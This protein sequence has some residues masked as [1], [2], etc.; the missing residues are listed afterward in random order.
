MDDRK[1]KRREGDAL[2]SPEECV[3]FLSVVMVGGGKRGE[4]VGREHNYSPPTTIQ[5]RRKKGKGN[6][7]LSTSAPRVIQTFTSS[8]KKPHRIIRQWEREG[9]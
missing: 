4:D 5:K 7:L 9:G 8:G 2:T 3:L 1:T 6:T